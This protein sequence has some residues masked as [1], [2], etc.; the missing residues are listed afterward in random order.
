MFMS[1][2]VLQFLLTLYSLGKNMFQWNFKINMDIHKVF[3]SI[4]KKKASW[5]NFNMLLVIFL[6]RHIYVDHNHVN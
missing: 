1:T 4:L 3:C 6:K 5:D 2:T